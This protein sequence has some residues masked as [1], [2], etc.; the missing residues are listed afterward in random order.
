MKQLYLIGILVAIALILLLGLSKLGG[1]SDSEAPVSPVA[2]IQDLQEEVL[3]NNTEDTMDTAEVQAS[4][5]NTLLVMKTNRGDI[6]IELYTKDMPITAGNFLKLAQDDFYDGVKFHRVIDGFM[7]QGGDPL[8]KD[9]SMAARWGTGG[10]GYAI[11]DEFGPRHSNAIGT[12]SMANS[13]PNTNGS[14]FFIVTADATPW[15]DGKHT[16][17]GE[18]VEGLDVV[19]KIDA[20]ETD[21]RDRPLEDVIL[22]SV[23][24]VK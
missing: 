10:P 13:G 18:V 8:T 5:G 20:V 2:D 16:N 9:D 3:P 1:R 19:E 11:E 15:L 23:E 24:L 7:I 14:Q 6:T 17:F 21:G 22:N 4:A 12:L